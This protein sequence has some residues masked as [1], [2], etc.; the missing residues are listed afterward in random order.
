LNFANSFINCKTLF[1]L[2]DDGLITAACGGGFGSL[3]GT[4]SILI[5]VDSIAGTGG[6]SSTSIFSGV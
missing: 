3:D 2:E 4:D 1:S 6:F 5:L